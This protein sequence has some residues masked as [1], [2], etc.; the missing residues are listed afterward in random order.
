M[1][2]QFQ[3]RAVF[4]GD[5]D[6]YGDVHFAVRSASTAAPAVSGI[7]AAEA[8][9]PVKT[10]TITLNAV[11]IPVAEADGYGSVAVLDLTADRA[12]SILN[13][14][15]DLT[16]VKDGTGYIAATDLDVSLG[17]D[18]TDSTTLAGD[19]VDVMPKQDLDTNA[20][21]V[22][23]GTVATPL[24]LHVTTSTGAAVYLNVAG[25]TETGENA[26][27]TVSGT[28]TLTLLDHGA[29]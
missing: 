23:T 17:L 2:E 18:P 19:F 27:L 28:I 21:S 22:V 10:V 24:I 4:I 9:N 6:F 1:P 29:A 12:L 15:V 7:T 20:L 25:P 11:E 13:S 26:T 5:A 8:Q 16:L 14:I 3:Q